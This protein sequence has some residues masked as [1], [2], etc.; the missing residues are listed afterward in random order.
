[1]TDQLKFPKLVLPD[2]FTER[3]VD[4]MARKG[5]LQASVETADGRQF[6][7]NFY[8]PGVLKMSVDDELSRGVPFAEPGIIVIPKV[9]PEEIERALRYLGEVNYFSDYDDRG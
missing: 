5:W 8:D 3:N 9:T 6:A 1:V 2:G 7:V 4:E